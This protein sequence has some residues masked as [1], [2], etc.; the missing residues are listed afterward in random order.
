MK[1]APKKRGRRAGQFGYIEERRKPVPGG[2][3]GD[4]VTLYRARWACPACQAALDAAHADRVARA[5]AEGLTAVPRRPRAQHHTRWDASKAAAQA[6]LDEVQRERRE[7]ALLGIPALCWVR[8]QED[9]SH[10]DALIFGP[11]FGLYADRVLNRSTG[12]EATRI[13]DRKH[14]DESVQSPEGRELGIGQ[15]WGYRPIRSI[16]RSEIRTWLRETEARPGKV[17]GTRFSPSQ[18]RQRFYLLRRI[19]RE[20]LEDEALEVDPTTGVKPPSLPRGRAVTGLLRA[21]EDQRWLPDTQTMQRVVAATA[22]RS[23]LGV[24]MLFGLGLRAGELTALLR[25]DLRRDAD[26]RWAVIISK[27]ESQS[28][29][30]PTSSGK[31]GR[32]DTRHCATWVA[33]E[34]EAHLARH[35]GMRPES[36]L[37]PAV[38]GAAPSLSHTAL[39]RDLRAAMQSLNLEPLSLQD[40]RAAGEAAVAERIGRPAAAQWARHGLQVQMAHY[41]AVDQEAVSRAAAGL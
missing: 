10:N 12:A 22:Q 6:V 17:E 11:T 26:G 15:R 5:A 16:T 7:Q 21:E 32:R 13:D 20:A 37:F 31:T 28:S 18:V 35:P 30:R 19:M 36:R 38:R 4:S 9:E 41:V 23:R 14:Y 29:G 34:I 24:T 1:Q 2:K 40:L 33:Q 27:S 25:N 8:D 3:R 39:R